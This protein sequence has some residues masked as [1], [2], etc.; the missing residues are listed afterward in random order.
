MSTKLLSEDHKSMTHHNTIPVGIIEGFFGRS[1][2]D[3]SRCA[4]A[5][6]LA[7]HQ[8][9][10]YI[11]APKNDTY[12]RRHWQQDWPAETKNQLLHLRNIYA[13]NQIAFGIGL[14]PLEI[15]RDTEDKDYSQYKKRLQQLNDLSPDILCILFDD[16]RGDLPDLANIQIE[17]THIAADITDA[18]KIIFCP[19]YYS[20]DPILEKV[21]GK[22]P[23]NYWQDLGKGMDESIE[24]FWTGEKVCSESY[25]SSHLQ[26]I[27]EIFQRKVF[28]W[29]N[30]PVND[31]A[32]KSQRLHLLPFHSSHADLEPYISGHAVNPM[33]QAYLSQ[34]PLLSL[35][36]AYKNKP[37]MQME[38]IFIEIGG[39]QLA[40]EL[41][42]DTEFF[43]TSGLKDL[44]ADQKQS[45]IDRYQAYLP[46]PLAIEVMDWLKGEYTFDPACLTE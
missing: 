18:N 9:D 14:S 41:L 35:A 27:E 43:Q 33:N 29:D 38:K 40:Q 44:N 22:M 7:Q 10:F 23:D 25:S 16:M 21:F 17:L 37:D 15:W 45:Y 2:S 3:E 46:H 24:F 13:D 20:T 5:K 31:G 26:S 36:I 6:F 39:E 19:S 34:I 28:L 1:W 8:F 12:L 4:Y 32:I 42:K 30:Y 11:Y